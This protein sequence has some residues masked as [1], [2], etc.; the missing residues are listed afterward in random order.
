MAPIVRPLKYNTNEE[1]LNA[2]R[3]SASQDYI[4]RI[5]NATEAGISETL[6]ALTKYRPLWNE[7]VDA[8]VNRIGTVIVRNMV[9]E[10][11][12][13]MFKRGMMHYGNTIEEVQV[14][15]LNAH[16]YD[17]DRE[18]ME[19]DLFGTERPWVES[20]FHS[21]NRQ[22]FY[23]VTVNEM[24]LRRAF[25]EDGGLSNFVSALMSAPATSD[26]VAEFELTMGLIPEYQRSNGFYNV[27]IPDVVAN[28]STEADSKAAL[29]K[30]RA[31]AGLL[32]FPSTKYNAA[33]MPT[34]AKPDELILLVSPQF[35]AAIDVE[36][37]AGA[38]NIE[39]AEMIGKIVTVPQSLFGVAGVQA[40]MT[41]P[42]FF[43]IADSVLENASQ[44]NPAALQTNYFLHHHSIIS[45]S[46]FV[47]AVTFGT[48]TDS[49][50]IVVVT[51]IDFSN[52]EIHD[53]AKSGVFPLSLAVGSIFDMGLFAGET[54]I[55][56][57]S[58]KV[59]GAESSK[60]YITKYGVLHVGLDEKVGGTL[61][62]TATPDSDLPGYKGE[63][64]TTT[65][66]VI[67]AD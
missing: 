20:N 8:L 18:Y 10:N 2:I 15:L 11:P 26:S 17:P 63:T 62:V 43:V 30:M 3:N 45:A 22:E 44:Y 27:N 51:P 4:R 21:V 29:R 60:T 13:A 25:L 42:D 35:Q 32:Q 46:R 52:L 54:R 65:F 36:A 49:E 24:L 12:L 57:V 33:G 37:L 6:S 40:L 39:K 58:W 61:T 9:W 23:K 48:G 64:A 38:F 53:Y 19:R 56:A 55:D 31:M 41:I 1:I 59:E 67:A 5:P 66:N 16:I 28:S 50:Q 7:F 34:F 14:G 47:P